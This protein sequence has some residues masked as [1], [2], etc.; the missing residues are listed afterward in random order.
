MNHK[1]CSRLL[2]KGSWRKR[3]SNAKYKD[4][5]DGLLCYVSNLANRQNIDFSTDPILGIPDPLACTGKIEF[6]FNILI[7][8]DTREF[9]AK[10]IQEV[11]L[12]T[13]VVGLGAESLSANVWPNVG[14]GLL[15][16]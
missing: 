2:V 12:V 3:V 13:G 6:D 15:Y 5:C 9:K 1:Q 4:A 8:I 14:N 11:F 16:V 10:E 7:I